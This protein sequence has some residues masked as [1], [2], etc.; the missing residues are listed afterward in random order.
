MNVL[1]PAPSLSIQ[2]IVLDSAIVPSHLQISPVC[3][4]PCLESL[5]RNCEKWERFP[6]GLS[7]SSSSSFSVTKSVGIAAVG[8]HHFC[9]AV[10]RLHLR[11]PQR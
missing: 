7:S 4:D 10:K 9:N 1:V 11:H 8:R 2:K 5:G 3:R 6:V